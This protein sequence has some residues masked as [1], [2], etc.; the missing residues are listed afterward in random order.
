MENEDI[1]R[2]V[3]IGQA[4]ISSMLCNLLKQQSAPDVD[5]D[6]DEPPTKFSKR[7]GLTGPQFLERGCWER[8]GD[9]FTGGLEFLDEK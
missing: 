6:L 8:G 4:D 1:G 5:V 9:F 3:V 7:G 2:T